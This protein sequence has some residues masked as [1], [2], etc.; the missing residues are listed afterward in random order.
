MPDTK[1]YCIICG[2]IAKGQWYFCSSKCAAESFTFRQNEN[3]AS[4]QGFCNICGESITILKDEVG[5]FIGKHTNCISTN[6]EAVLTDLQPKINVV[7]EEQT[8]EKKEDFLYRESLSSYESIT[9]NDFDYIGL[10]AKF[11]VENSEPIVSGVTNS[12]RNK[13]YY[14]YLQAAIE[15]CSDYDGILKYLPDFYLLICKIASDDKASWYTKMLVNAALSYLVLEDDIVSDKKSS[16]GYIDDLYVFAYVLK[17]I[18]DKVSKNIILNNVDDFEYMGN[19]FEII[20]DVFNI[21]S[22]YLEDKTDYILDLVGLSAFSPFYCL[23]DS[24]NSKRL[25]NR[26]EK[27]RLLYAMLAVKINQILDEEDAFANLKLKSLI[28]DSP[29]F[30]DIKTYME[31][32][33]GNK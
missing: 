14:D 10:A 21:S 26:K 27:R 25:T 17:E 1:R 33:D 7:P 16:K 19:I 12:T 32:I 31:F 6:K 28:F 29:E 5:R 8:I 20:Y 30:G 23:Y 2:S 24:N 3:L 15:D 13:N 9:H 18:R 22:S 4:I 11:S